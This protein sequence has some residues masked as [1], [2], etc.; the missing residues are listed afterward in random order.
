VYRLLGGR[1]RGAIPLYVSAWSDRKPSIDLLVARAE[2]TKADGFR[3]IKIYPMEFSPLAEAE[4]CVH[5]VREAIGWD[6]DLMIDLNGLDNSYLAIRAA[7]AFE[8][9]EPFW[10]EEPVSSDDLSALSYVRAA[11]RLRIVSGERHG[12]IFRFREILEC[13]AADVLNPDICGC[14]GILEFLAISA[15]AQAFSAQMTPHNYNSMTIGMAAMLHVSAVI[16]NLLVAEYV[17]AF[18]A[19]SDQLAKCDFRIADGA[20]GLPDAPGLGVAMNEQAL[21][22]LALSE[23]VS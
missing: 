23:T 22:K 13:R 6:A 20:A 15:L 16:P 21:T 5:R 14:G 10:F 9:Y 17:P 2:K 8:R 3:A 7:R 12:G 19:M 1:L 4:A 11:S 18:Q